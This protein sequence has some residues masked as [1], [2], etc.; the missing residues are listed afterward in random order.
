MSYLPTCLTCDSDMPENLSFAN[1]FVGPDT[2]RISDLL[3]FNGDLRQD[4]DYFQVANKG[5]G[6][7]NITS[8]SGEI[9]LDP[10]ET[11]TFGRADGKALFDHFQITV[12]SDT[13]ARISWDE[14]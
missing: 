5:L 8:A 6:V 14:I 7:I 3:A 13:I 11:E 12:P 9:N 4:V 10:G 2:L 1:D